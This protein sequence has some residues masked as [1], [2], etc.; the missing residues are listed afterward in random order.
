MRA[1]RYV[2]KRDEGG[3]KEQFFIAENAVR[4]RDQ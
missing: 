1:A 2:E 4:E 3:V